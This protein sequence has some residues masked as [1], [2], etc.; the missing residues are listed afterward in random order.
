MASAAKSV[1]ETAAKAA[2]SVGKAVGGM[3]E[4][5]VKYS[6]HAAALYGGHKV[7]KG[8]SQ[9]PATQKA[10]SFVP[11]TQQNEIREYN[12]AV[13]RQQRGY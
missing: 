6:P 12:K 10:L 3:A 1:A 11:G 7:Y 2:P 13:E 4:F 9:H 8:V 5:G